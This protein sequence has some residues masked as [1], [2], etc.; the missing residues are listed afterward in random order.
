MDLQPH[1][2]DHEAKMA[3]ADLF[4][5]A[6]YSFKLFKMIHE[7]M[8]LE[9]WVQA[10]ITKAADYIASVYHYME[11]EM[12]FSEYGEK[13]EQSD[14]YSTMSESQRRA[15][16]NM[17]SEAKQ[18]MKKLN[19][20]QAKKLKKKDAKVEEG[21]PTVDSAKKDHEEREKSKGTGKFDKKDT[22]TGTQYTRK[23]STFTDGGDDS[24]TKAAKKKAKKVDEKFGG[25]QNMLNQTTHKNDDPMRRLRVTTDHP[26]FKDKPLDSTS[27]GILKNRLKSDQ[28]THSKPNL[29]DAAMADEDMDT[30]SKG[31][32]YNPANDAPQKGSRASQDALKAAMAKANGG[33]PTNANAP[34]KGS[35]AS[36]DALKA[37]MAKAANNEGMMD[38]VKSAAKKVGKAIT[39]G[40]DED[41]RKDLQ[42]KMGVAQTGK[43]P[44]QKTTEA[45]KAKKDYDGDGKIESGKDEYLGSRIAAAKKAGK[46][47]EA[48]KCNHSPKGKSCPVHGL[49]ECG[50]MYE[51]DKFDPL[52]H[53][54]NPTQGEKTAAKDVK[55]GSYAD[56][57]AMLKSAEA[58]G[59][60]KKESTGDYSAKK[61]AAGK[62]I[63]KPGKN[64][65]K[66][67]KSAGGGEKGKRIAGAVLAKLRKG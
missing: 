59:R 5:L 65:A 40:S 14:M 36:Q 56:R 60:L 13:L 63:G 51:G 37:A 43:K 64:F 3:R 2:D 12:K 30:V 52:K 47:A 23:A 38:T 25:T 66:I 6:Q 35:Q 31:G 4:K 32:Y 62:D 27:Q 48:S 19:A 17:L 67:E 53:V 57:A 34:V 21:F 9:G 10:K 61:A 58:D 7:D 1:P 26:R 50:G 11:Y 49:K 15:V 54:K 46:M 8:E 45:A 39:G 18:T 41:Q 22:G 55:R 44:A 24:D 42:R 29:P 33:Q 28:G 20:A 16:R